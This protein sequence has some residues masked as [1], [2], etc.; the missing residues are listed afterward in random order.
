MRLTK[1][2]VRPT[3]F[4]RTIGSRPDVCAPTMIGMPMLPNATGAV[5]ASR[6]RPAAWRGRNPRPII[7]AAVM[8]TGVP[9]PAHPSMNAPNEKAMSRA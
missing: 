5:L 4:A 8:A 6:H 1:G 9:K 2:N 7:M 3:I